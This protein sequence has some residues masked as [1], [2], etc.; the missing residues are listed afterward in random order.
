MSATSASL[1][2]LPRSTDMRE[3][4]WHSLKPQDENTRMRIVNREHDS[5]VGGTP[6]LAFNYLDRYLDV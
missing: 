4:R 2:A 3:R 6:Y 5:R 1:S